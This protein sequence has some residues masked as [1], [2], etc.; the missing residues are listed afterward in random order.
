[1]K[2][3]FSLNFY[4]E[5]LQ[6]IKIAAIIFFAVVLFTSAMGSVTHLMGYISTLSDPSATV[7]KTVLSL[8][9]V[10]GGGVTFVTVFV[11]LLTVAVFAFLY[12]RNEAD[13]YE[14]LPYSKREILISSVLAV[15]TV[16]VVTLLVSS[17]VG[18]AILAPCLGKTVEYRFVKGI[19][20]LLGLIFC[21]AVTISG[22]VLAV[23]VTGTQR[24]GIFVSFV[25][26]Y[27]PRMILALLNYYVEMLCPTLMSGH[28]IPLFD[29]NYS[30]HAALLFGN[31]KVLTSPMA[32][33]YTLILGILYAVCGYIL[34][35]KRK[36]EYATHSFAGRI[37]RHITSVLFA[38]F[39]VTLGIFLVCLDGFLIVIAL[40]VFAIAV[41]V[42]FAY[43]LSTGRKERGI[44]PTFVAFPILI[45]LSGVLALT[46]FLSSLG[47][48]SYSPK[49]EEIKSVS[50]VVPEADDWYTV[51]SY[52]NYVLRR[53]EKVTLTD[54]ESKKIVSDAVKRGVHL[55]TYNGYTAVY[56]KIKTVGYSYR[57]LYVTDEEYATLNRKLAENKEYEKLWLRVDEG[58]MDPQIFG[59][60]NIGSEG[61]SRVLET[62]AAEVS[63]VG[64][65]KWFS[66]CTESYSDANINYYAEIDGET[67]T[68][69]LPIPETMP[70][71]YAAYKAEEKLA[72]EKTYENIKSAVYSALDGDGEEMTLY[73]SFTYGA[74]D[75]YWI[76]TYATA[77]D[78]EL[79][80]ICDKLFALVSPEVPG[81]D[82]L[83]IYLNVYGDGLYSSDYYCSFKVEKENEE[84]LLELFK[85]YGE[86]YADY[87]EEYVY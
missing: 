3:F 41:G 9:D 18:V 58:A 45:G 70:K 31:D 63:E 44:A 25:L 7:T 35:T 13:F 19:F 76:D 4:L 39:I 72:A 6:R 15:F 78:S 60:V 40:F 11:P 28:A 50:M 80:G 38:L 64:F 17:G 67:W 56:L 14:A 57:Y 68:V 85:E 53:A 83:S 75:T 71:T 69:T 48:N 55:D 29:N 43:S 1:M 12:K 62:L 79:R 10:V 27:V 26:L 2:K 74:K 61:A 73:F 21:S 51:L 66:A 42:Y 37:F 84:K 86:S 54:D 5:S 81:S 59:S 30:I 33:V 65:E 87:G 49:P 32:Y 47:F 8:T 20:E 36:S 82:D 22:T 24:N 77:G 34:F 23:S 16:A 46:V 52:N